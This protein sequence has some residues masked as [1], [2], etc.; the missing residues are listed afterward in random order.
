MCIYLHVYTQSNGLFT[1]TD[2]HT[3]IH[4]YTHKEEEKRN[5]Q[6]KEEEEEGKRKKFLPNSMPFGGEPFYLS[7]SLLSAGSITSRK[8][9]HAWAPSDFS[10]LTVDEEDG[11]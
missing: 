8:V 2:I 4:T 10:C 1:D 9:I 5:A 3:Y 11:G 6:A 7:Q